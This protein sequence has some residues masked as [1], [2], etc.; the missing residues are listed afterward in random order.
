MAL[1]AFVCNLITVPRGA[2]RAF[3]SREM[4]FPTFLRYRFLQKS[5][6]KN[7]ENCI[8]MPAAC[9]AFLAAR[10][11]RAGAW[12]QHRCREARMAVTL[13]KSIQ[14]KLQTIFIR[15]GLQGGNLRQLYDRSESTVLLY[16]NSN[17]NRL[18]VWWYR[19]LKKSTPQKCW[20]THFR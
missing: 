2:F 20:E 7:H 8:L 19:F 13:G 11:W 12:M 14:S 6:P 16:T 3:N 18:Q 5:I 1:I 15:E 17:G 9:A 4:R 10:P